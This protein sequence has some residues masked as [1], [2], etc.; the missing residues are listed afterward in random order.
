MPLE[1]AALGGLLTVMIRVTHSCI[2]VTHSIQSQ[3]IEFNILLKLWWLFSLNTSQ[4]FFTT[5]LFPNLLS[6]SMCPFSLLEQTPVPF[7]KYLIFLFFSIAIFILKGSQHLSLRLVILSHPPL[8]K[9][10]YTISIFHLLNHSQ[11]IL[12]PP[13]NY[14]NLSNTWAR[15]P[16]LLP[17]IL[18]FF[19]IQ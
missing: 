1:V 18:H 16:Y 12:F 2:V 17:T 19:H 7:Y 14:C 5:T 10:K 8:K 9:W 4:P 13:N 15:S 11:S 6:F 3:Y